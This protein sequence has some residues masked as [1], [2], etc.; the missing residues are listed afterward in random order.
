MRHFGYLDFSG[1]SH[2]ENVTLSFGCWLSPSTLD[3]LLSALAKSIRSLAHSNL[4]TL[5]IEIQAQRRE[6][7]VPFLEPARWK[8]VNAALAT[9]DDEDE[10]SKSLAS[11]RQVTLCV[12]NYEYPTFSAEGKDYES[13]DRAV[14]EATRNL[15][16]SLS[17]TGQ[18]EGDSSKRRFVLETNFADPFI[19]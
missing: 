12:S 8:A 1:N 10:E 5:R 17:S 13:V 11:L 4:T 15:L 14:E 6:G 18:C 16:P 2:L 7:V 9:G 19:W 3:R